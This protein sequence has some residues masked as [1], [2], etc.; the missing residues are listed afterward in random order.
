MHT[1]FT[2]CRIAFKNDVC[3]LNQACQF[4]QT[5]LNTSKY[6]ILGTLLD[7][8]SILFCLG[9]SVTNS[10]RKLLQEKGRS[11]R[12]QAGRVSPVNWLAEAVMLCRLMSIAEGRGPCRLLFAKYSFCKPSPWTICGGTYPNILFPDRSTV[13]SELMEAHMVSSKGR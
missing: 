3:N 2:S 4:I 9:S 12:V 7:K 13:S 5:S 6:T 10:K 11:D 1:R 8:I